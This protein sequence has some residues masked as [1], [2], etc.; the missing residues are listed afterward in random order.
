MPIG[1]FMFLA[2]FAI[3]AGF[4]VI[5]QRNPVHCVLALALVL[6]DLGVLF[7][8][9]DAVTLGFL[10]IIVY[11]GAIMVL[12]LFVIWLLN[13]QADPG[14]GRHLGLKLFG[15]IA[16]AA[17]AAEFAAI[18]VHAPKIREIRTLPADFGTV[19]ALARSLFSDYL[20]AFEVTSVLLL[21]AIVG[22]IALARKV[23][24]PLVLVTPALSRD[25]STPASSAS[26]PAA[27]R[28]SA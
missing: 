24:A 14:A 16:A 13:I 1:I 10:Q 3:I 4:G 9:L 7:M 8:G 5:M 22:A 21:A 26:D 25:V 2:A 23:S 6:I 18:I 27:H 17:L 12:F 11:V 20:V 15:S 28:K 19:A